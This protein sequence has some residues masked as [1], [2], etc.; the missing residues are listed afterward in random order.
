M[1]KLL[2]GN[3]FELPAEEV[4]DNDGNPVSITN[5]TELTCQEYLKVD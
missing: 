3:G 5:Y 1:D 2:T 4:I